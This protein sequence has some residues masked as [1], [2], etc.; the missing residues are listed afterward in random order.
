MKN[1][2]NDNGRQQNP[3]MRIIGN[4]MARRR[5]HREY[6]Q[7]MELPNAILDDIGITRLDIQAAMAGRPTD[8]WRARAVVTAERHRFDRVKPHNEA[9]VIDVARVA[10]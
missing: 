5:A 10:A 9:L 3:L 6:L 7:M 2:A 8:A 1:A 4:F